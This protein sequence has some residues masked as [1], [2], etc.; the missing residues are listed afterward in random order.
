MS[1]MFYI[2]STIGENPHLYILNNHSNLLAD[3]KVRSL[4]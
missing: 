2:D 3:I 4:N 1:I